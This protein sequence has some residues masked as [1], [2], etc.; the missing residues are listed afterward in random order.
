MK[1]DGLIKALG[2]I[3]D[4]LIDD[5]EKK[6]AGTAWVKWGTLA[7]AFVLVAAMCVPALFAKRT[8]PTMSGGT[9]GRAKDGVYDGDISFPDFDFPEGSLVYGGAES[10]VRDSGGVSFAE[11]ES[12]GKDVLVGRSPAATSPWVWILPVGGVFALIVVGVCA[13]RKT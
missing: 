8:T 7:A 12:G 10:D 3:D 11:S 1:S 6:H 2:D 9:A 5:S 13:L 4:E